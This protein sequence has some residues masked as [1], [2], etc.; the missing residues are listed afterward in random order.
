[1]LERILMDMMAYCRNFVDFVDDCHY[2]S[3]EVKNGKI[4]LPFFK[5]G[6]FIFIE[7]K[8]KN[9]GLHSCLDDLEDEEFTGYVYTLWIDKDF[10]ELAREIKDWKDKYSDVINSPY[11]SESF[12][13][14]TYKKSAGSDGGVVASWSKQFSQQLRRWK[15]L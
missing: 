2:G 10:V 1:M 3:Y 11:D 14:Y 7:G 15:K 13:G 9:S 4:N 5:D 6:Q 12:G 8:C